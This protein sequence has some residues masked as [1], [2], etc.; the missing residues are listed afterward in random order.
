M[1]ARTAGPAACKSY[2]CAWIYWWVHSGQVAKEY[3]ATV[4]SPAVRARLQAGA[5]PPSLSGAPLVL[6]DLTLP[7]SASHCTPPLHAPG[8]SLLSRALSR[9]L[10]CGGAHNSVP[11]IR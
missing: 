3:L 8:C 9:V 10:S 11:L 6:P 7:C 4:G 1:L 2:G 5:H